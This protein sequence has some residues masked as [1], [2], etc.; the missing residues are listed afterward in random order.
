M[1]KKRKNF[2]LPNGAGSV[3]KLPGN[4]RN[5]WTAVMHC[6]YEDDG[7]AIRKY[8]GYYPT[9]EDAI[10]ALEMY[11]E[12]PFDLNNKEITIER[13]YAIVRG[14]KEN[15]A[16]ETQKSHKNS[17][18]QLSPLHNKPI[19]QIKVY[20][21]QKLMDELPISESSKG[22]VK[23][24]ISLLYREALKLEVVNKNLAQLIE[25]KPSEE[26]N[27][28]IPFTELEIRK[29]WQAAKTEPFAEVPLILCYTGMRPQELLNIRI[30]DVHLADGYMEGGMKTK[31]GKGRKIPIHAA[32]YA[33]VERR[34]S[35]NKNYLIQGVR[36]GKLHYS[37]MLKP[38]HELMNNLGLNH[39]PHDGRSTFA[40]LAKKRGIDPYFVKK[41]MGHSTSD[42][43]E[44]HYTKVSIE[45]LIA[46][47]NTI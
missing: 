31:A 33:I 32:I 45:D 5:P 20:Q 34:V 16:K 39:V 11:K 17:Y 21:W 2:R 29:L 46:V 24:F 14:K 22:P 12:T 10:H 23:S 36:G 41:I 27:L 44:K 25:I 7:R 15:A 19:R 9:Q 28:H 8:I 35:E 4:R 47:A 30:E 43:T 1:A 38:W 40:T 6:G 13:L 18:R 26:S 42:I 3:Y 37:N